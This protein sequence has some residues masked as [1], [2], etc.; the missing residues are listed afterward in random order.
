MGRGIMIMGES[1]SG[2]STSIRNLKG[3]GIINVYGKPLP[4]KGADKSLTVIAED[5]CARVQAILQ[6]AKAKVIVID[7]FQG[8]LVSQYMDRA[9]EKG[10]D[11][12]SQMAQSYYQLIRS[13]ERLPDDVRVYFL[14]HSET[15]NG[16]EK[17]KTLGKMLDSAV[18]VEGLFAVVLK[19]VAKD[20]EYLFQVK[21]TGF[22]TVKSPMGMFGDEMYVPNDLAEVDKAVCEFFD[23]GDG[24]EERKAA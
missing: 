23:I 24:N 2:K 7:D 11:K 22:D 13:I 15:E 3:A 20:G 21:T 19:A 4:F 16:R 8:L 12:F 14:S 18:T 9:L 6:K 1:G 10:Y 17:V 5:S